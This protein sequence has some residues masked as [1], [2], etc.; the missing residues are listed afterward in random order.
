MFRTRNALALGAVLALSACDRQPPPHPETLSTPPSEDRF[1]GARAFADLRAIAER[2]ERYYGAPER[3]AALVALVERL[4]P[5]V[6]R[7]E[8][9]RFTREHPDGGGHL[10]MVNVLG[11]QHPEKRRRLIVGSHWDT[12]LWAEED[13]DPSRADQPIVGANDGTSGIAVLIELAR[14]LE[15]NPLGA[16]GVDYVLFDGEEYGRPGNNEYCQGSMYLAEHLSQWYAG[17]RPEGGIIMD[18]V[19]DADLQIPIE[20]FSRRNARWLV[21]TVWD[22]ARERGETAFESD[23]T[24]SIIDDHVPLSEAGVPSI[25]LIDY[26]YPYWHTHG[27]TVERCSAESLARVG[28]VVLA[29]LRRIDRERATSA[30]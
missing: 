18:M 1:D 9:Q 21:D 28:S 12:R 11:R 10:E 14:A 15:T 20:S 16:F 3:E 8:Y 17:N 6:A 7:I 4:Q 26:D 2:G 24:I 22:T 25:L 13:S 23:R 29:S 30:R 27:D 5:H 19:A